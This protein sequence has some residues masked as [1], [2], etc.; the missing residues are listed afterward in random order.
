MTALENAQRFIDTVR[1]DEGAKFAGPCAVEVI[2]EAEARLGLRFPPSYRLSLEE[3]GTCDINGEEILGLFEQPSTPGTIWGALKE[4]LDARGDTALPDSCIVFYYDGM[5]GSF[6]LDTAKADSEGEAPVYLWIGGA[7]QPGDDL[8][9]ISADFGACAL[10][11]ATGS[12][13]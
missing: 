3:L 1:A 13:Y 12:L 10:G 4:T 2:S 9:M 6:V 11:L 8:E 7:S 5:G